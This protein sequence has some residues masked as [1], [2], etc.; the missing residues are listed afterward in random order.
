MLNQKLLKIEREDSYNKLNRLVTGFKASHPEVKVISLGIGDVS[1]P[2]PGP[3]VEAMKKA[4]G[5]L[6][7]MK[8]FQGYGAYWGL[9]SLRKTIASCDYGDLGISFEEVYVGDGTK[10]DC[11]AVLE[12]L[13]SSAKVLTGDPTY[14]VYKNG[15]L[16]MGR[17]VFFAE[18]DEEFKM[19]VPKERYDVI[20]IC[21]PCNPVGNAYTRTELE[22]WIDYAGKNG[23]YIVYDNVYRDFAESPDIPR[24]IYELEGSRE[25]CIE[26]HSFSKN[27]S[28]SGVRCSYFILPKEFGQEVHDLWRERTI[29][30]FNGASYVAQKAAEASYLP[31]AREII[32]RNIKAY[33]ENGVLLRN[34]LKKAGFDVIGGVDAPYLWVRTPDGM[35]CWEAF[36]FFLEKLGLV[37]VPGSIFGSGG[38]YHL[39]ISALGSSADCREAC[40]RIEEYYE[41][42][43]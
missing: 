10:T 5:D 14:P 22:K 11:T 3:V 18:C 27:A 39:R 8:T 23:S 12:L 36:G 33:K 34:T 6:A 29:N 28:L 16:A 17:E 21:S 42:G 43:I 32:S 24:S 20:Y 41:K 30:R 4:C 26:M 31:N 25:C 1:F 38:R 9:D 2:V 15:S 40:R 37:T 19:I 7:D 13:D 35:E